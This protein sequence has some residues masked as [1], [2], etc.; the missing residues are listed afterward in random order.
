MSVH[1]L[2]NSRNLTLK[3]TTTITKR[4]CG[5]SRKKALIGLLLFCFMIPRRYQKEEL[6]IKGLFSGQKET[7]K[8]KEEKRHEG[9]MI[10]FVF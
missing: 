7:K 3:T 6:V 5:R 4:D 1:A 2:V 8:E 10:P 9:Q